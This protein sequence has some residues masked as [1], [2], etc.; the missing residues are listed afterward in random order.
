MSMPSEPSAL[1]SLESL[2]LPESLGYK[3]K[4]KLLGPP[5]NTVELSSERL[6][7]P[8][9]LAVLSS[10]CIS[11]S[12]YSTEAM[13]TVLVPAVGAAAFA[14]ILPITLGVVVIL[15]FVTLSYR[16]VVNVYTKAG[17]SYVVARENF[18]L[19]VAQVAAVSLLIDYTLTVAVSVAAGTAALTSAFPVL[20]PYSLGI[21]VAFVLLIAFGNLRGAREAGKAF[22]APTFFFIANVALLIVVGVVKASLGMLHAHSLHAAGAFH[23]G[24]AGEGLFLGASL[25]IVLR[26]FASGGSA[27][28]G[29]EAI[30]NGVSVFRVPESRNARQTLAIM[31]LVLG[32]A[33]IGISALASIVHPIPFISGTPTVISQV[34]RYVY[35][36]GPLGAIL[37]YLI[38]AATM[39]ILVLAANTSFTGFPYLASFAAEDAYLPKQLTRRGH[40]LV[41][42]NG[43]LVLTAVSVALLLVS[44]AKV[45]KLIPLYA[46]GVFTS[47]TMAG[48]GMVKHHLVTREPA[49]LRKVMI[50]ASAA[51]LSFIVD[52][53]FAV[54]KFTEGAWVVVVALPL[55][56]FLLIR[57]HKRYAWEDA[58]LE[59][60][61]QRA[62]SEPV[63]RRHVVLVLVDRLDLATAKAIRY[64]R[65]LMANDLRAVHFVL[66][67]RVADELESGWS[68]LELAR[69]PL[70]VVDCPDRRLGRAALE[71]AARETR[72]GETEVTVVL[73]RRRYG[74]VW[75]H[76]F[77]D[78][79]ADHI[80]ALVSTL[81][82]ATATIVPYQIGGAAKVPW[83]RN[84]AEPE[85][86]DRSRSSEARSI[87]VA[88][89]ALGDQ[90]AVEEGGEFHPGEKGSGTVLAQPSASLRA[91]NE[92]TTPIG[93]VTWRKWARVT[94]RVESVTLRPRSGE[95][96][97]ECTV[98][99]S[100][101]GINLVFRGQRKV[102]G[103]EPGVILTAEGVVSSVDQRFAI[104]D[105]H[106]ELAI[107]DTDDR[108]S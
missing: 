62:C 47:F 59:E 42:S 31:S 79:T 28:T 25:F 35:G 104:L 52:I 77:H 21:S 20:V 54:T 45:D 97:V 55:G 37:Y 65:G 84:R 98:V 34:A 69:L 88:S 30:S 80:A 17:G 60:G 19:N 46:I 24:H 27:L 18:G 85:S 49:W 41:F 61:A 66:D 101:G 38:Q 13:L 29:V 94:G 8:T 15:A 23:P 4:N 48:A 70:D 106:Y 44:G 32:V 58:Q 82:H 105:P 86:E 2:Q 96:S 93:N 43:V 33:I 68:N 12:A 71:V 14:M 107:S 76:F 51:I 57:L 95:E 11:S 5:L 83:G 50:N 78:R 103:L 53:V 10:D 6:G 100:T 72:D 63:L 3:L 75:G 91:T 92:P 40:R 16:E 56:V 73:P 39:L 81:D 36:S 108:R 102:A 89:D 26:A 87:A 64:A 74:W 7:K 1:E 22:A 67:S 99:D 9:A 90:S